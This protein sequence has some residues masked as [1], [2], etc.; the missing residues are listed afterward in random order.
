MLASRQ[1]DRRRMEN[2][3][4]V[5]DY[6]TGF[7]INFM[8]NAEGSTLRLTLGCLLS[9]NLGIQLRRVGSG[10]R[11]TFA[12]G[13]QALS[14]WMDE[15]AFVAWFVC[16]TPWEAEFALLGKLSLPLNLDQNRNHNFHSTLSALR[17]SAKERARNLTHCVSDIKLYIQ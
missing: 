7:V 17:K 3:R 6:L 13:E 15:N 10:N 5:K 4:V 11:M 8:G 12:A 16:E 1:D 2:H 14:Q 9:E